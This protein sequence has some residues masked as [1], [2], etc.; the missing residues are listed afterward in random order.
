MMYKH[1][2]KLATCQEFSILCAFSQYLYIFLREILILTT[3]Q[4]FEVC[5]WN[6]K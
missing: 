3:L 5:F 6:V 4:L 2:L 1:V